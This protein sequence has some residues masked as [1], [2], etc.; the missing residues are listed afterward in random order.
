MSPRICGFA[1]FK[2]KFACPALQNTQLRGFQIENIT[3]QVNDT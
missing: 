1:D 3:A 2:K